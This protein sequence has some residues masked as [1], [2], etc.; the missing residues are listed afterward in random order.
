MKDFLILCGIVVVCLIIYYMWPVLVLIAL[1][2]L[3]FYILK[4]VGEKNEEKERREKIAREEEERKEKIRKEQEEDRIWRER[5]LIDKDIESFFKN[6]Y[7]NVEKIK[8][9]FLNSR[10]S[11]KKYLIDK[12]SEKES[13]LFDS[14]LENIGN[15]E[16]ENAE[17]LL[18]LLALFYPDNKLYQ[19]S[20]RTSKSAL[21]IMS[22]SKCYVLSEEYGK[23]DTNILDSIRGNTFEEM[24][25]KI[26]GKGLRYPL[27]YYAIKKP[28]DLTSYKNIFTLIR[29][30]SGK[31]KVVSIDLLASIL[32]IEK[33]EGKEVTY[34]VWDNY[35]R[36]IEAYIRESEEKELYDFSSAMCWMN[37][38]EIEYRC[39]K[40][41]IDKY[42]LK[43]VRERK[44]ILEKKFK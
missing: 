36:D 39:L 13:V 1:F 2:I 4:K 12:I 30:I 5:N 38:T 11:N 26:S 8:M 32:Y 41:L 3:L 14:A 37:Q 18:S 23:P 33:N 27:W 6:Y 22:S 9:H 29:T 7:P 19:N 42:N 31:H 40:V 44:E 24:K 20:L 10:E 25:E 17:K 28:F 15:A 21:A 35:Q 16:F 43:S 34:K